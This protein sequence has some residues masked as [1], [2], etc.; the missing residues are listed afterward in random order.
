MTRSYNIHGLVTPSERICFH[1]K[2]TYYG[3][4]KSKYCSRLCSEHYQYEASMLKVDWRLNRL[5][6]MAKNRS[7]SKELDFD[8]DLEYLIELWEKNQGCCAVSK[9]PFELGRS[10]KGKVHPYAPSIDRIIPA[11]GYIKGNVRIVVYQLNISLS[12]FGLEQFTS[13]ISSYITNNRI[14]LTGN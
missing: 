8:L 14:S 4:G 5:L 3:K 11:K 2:E 7:K 12:E 6:Y 13:F 9:I 1:C 10:E